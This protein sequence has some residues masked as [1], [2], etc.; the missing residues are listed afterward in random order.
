MRNNDVKW[1]ETGR[2]TNQLEKC[3][4]VTPVCHCDNDKSLRHTRS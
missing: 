3:A 4:A 2:P 1:N